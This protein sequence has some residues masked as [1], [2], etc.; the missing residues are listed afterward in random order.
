MAEVSREVVV[1]VALVRL[2]LAELILGRA[3]L[4]T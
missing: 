2:R 3:T 1:L 4:R